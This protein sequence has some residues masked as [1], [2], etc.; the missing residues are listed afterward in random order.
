MRRGRASYDG[1]PFADIV[2]F[3]DNGQWYVRLAGKRFGPVASRQKAIDT[4]QL[5]ERSGKTAQVLEQ[6]RL[7]DFEKHW[8]RP[9]RR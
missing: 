1:R 5:A 3:N 6:T 2:V 8:P 9:S 4:A 7:A